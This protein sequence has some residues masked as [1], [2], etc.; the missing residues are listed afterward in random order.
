MSLDDQK[1]QSNRMTAAWWWIDRWRK[2]T[3]YTDMTAEEQGLYRNLLDEIWL[4]ETHTIPDDQRILAKVSGDPEAWRRS[5]ATVLR[6][7]LKTDAGWTHPTA[8]QVIEQSRNRADRQ[9]RF[10]DRLRN[11]Q[12]NADH[13]EPHNKA[14]SPSPSP[15]PSPLSALKDKEQIHVISNSEN[16]NGH[17]ELSQKEFNEITRKNLR[18]IPIGPPA[19]SKS[20]VHSKKQRRSVRA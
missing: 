3:A 19:L 2:S 4:R 15:S 13:N 6:W 12:R 7:M 5:G 1:S 9:R 14:H 16:G 18:A 8:M 11:G 10:R 17:K 20:H